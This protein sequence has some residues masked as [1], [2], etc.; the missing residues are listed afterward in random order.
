MTKFICSADGRNMINVA[1]IQRIF[2][3]H[4][5]MPQKIARALFGKPL[6]T[7]IHCE[8]STLGVPITAPLMILYEV[9]SIARCKLGIGKAERYLKALTARIETYQLLRLL[10]FELQDRLMGGMAVI[11]ACKVIE[12]AI[13]SHQK[14]LFG[15]DLNFEELKTV[16][17]IEKTTLPRSMAIGGYMNISNRRPSTRSSKSTNKEQSIWKDF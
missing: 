10:M 3:V 9:E 12:S 11:D 16:L 8:I 7:G 15:D 1:K 14:K 17:G 5:L 4:E 13:D 6:G 2:E